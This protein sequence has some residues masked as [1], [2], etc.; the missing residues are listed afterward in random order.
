MA[1]DS[2][3]EVC[4]YNPISPIKASPVKATQATLEIHRPKQWFQISF[5]ATKKKPKVR[6]VQFKKL[7]GVFN[8]VLE[9]THCVGTL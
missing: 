3:E 2:Y 1:D 9:S 7:K 6:R 5:L 8:N 4:G